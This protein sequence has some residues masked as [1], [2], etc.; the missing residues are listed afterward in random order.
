MFRILVYFFRRINNL[1]CV[2]VRVVFAFESKELVMYAMLLSTWR[3]YV[4]DVYVRVC[5][6]QYFSRIICKFFWFVQYLRNKLVQTAHARNMPT[7]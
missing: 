7:T 2:C 1:Q 4:Y 3:L 6:Q 5:M